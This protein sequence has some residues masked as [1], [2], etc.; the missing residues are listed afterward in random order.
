MRINVC[1]ANGSRIYCVCNGALENIA[2]L[3]NRAGQ[4][5]DPE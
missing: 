5:P 3:L 4:R 2:Q 1:G